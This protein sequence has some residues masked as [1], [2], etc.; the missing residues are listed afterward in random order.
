MLSN[1]VLLLIRINIIIGRHLVQPGKTGAGKN[2]HDGVQIINEVGIVHAAHGVEG[3]RSAVCG[4]PL[5]PDHVI[6]RGSGDERIADFRRSRGVVGVGFAPIT[7]NDQRAG[8][9]QTIGRIRAND[10][11]RFRGGRK[12]YATGGRCRKSNAEYPVGV[13]QVVGNNR[14]NEG[15]IRGPAAEGER[16]ATGRVVHARNGRAAAGCV[17]DRHWVR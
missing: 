6:S 12:Q 17:I 5:E 10:G 15:G 4:G 14:N 3:H 16:T 13:H 1:P 11:H 8:E 2:G 7:R 9:T